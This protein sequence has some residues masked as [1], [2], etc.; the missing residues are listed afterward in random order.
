MKQCY[1]C[2]SRNLRIIKTKLRHNIKRNVFE[3][4]KCGLVFL[5]PKKT[6]LQKYYKKGYREIYSPIIGKEL[7]S[8][9]IF[10]I[11]YPMQNERVKEVKKYLNKKKRVLDIGCSAGHFL[12]SI[13]N[14][15]KECIGIEY[16]E[17]NAE[18][19][20]KKLGIK[21]YTEPVE[22]TDIPKKYF[23]VI[24]CFQTLEHIDDPLKF[25]KTIKEY[26]KDDGIIYI[27]V[28]NV[29]EATLSIYKN[30]EYY[31]FYYKEPHLFYYSPK[32]LSNLMRKAGYKG[33]VLPFQWY[34]F[35]NQMNWILAKK[36]QKSGAD[37]MGNSILI[38]S[39]EVTER[40]RNDFNKWIKDKDK[41]YKNLLKKYLITD[42][43]V[44]VGKKN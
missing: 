18:F 33:E 44:F 1:L 22:K 29:L 9:E 17:K 38:N 25:L 19:V 35:L 24:F 11:Y 4:E 6:N 27:K 14:N 34:N 40:I 5:E 8:K 31:D 32:T 21:V 39:K 16:N 43:I 26:L 42:Y 2:K 23:D 3:C 20:N 15:V 36:P 37:G 10:D 13:K 7:S 12:Y 30:K 41:E 28:P